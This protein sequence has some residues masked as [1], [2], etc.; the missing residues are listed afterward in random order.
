MAKK[1][2]T[3]LATETTLK[4]G[5]YVAIDHTT[6]GTKKLN[7]GAELTDLKEELEHISGISDDVKVALLQIASKVAYIDDGGQDYYDALYNALYPPADLVSISAVYTQ[8]GTVHDTDTLDSL[9][10]DLVVTALYSDQTTQTVTSYTLSGTLEVGTSTITVSYGGKTTTFTVTV[11]EYSPYT[12]YDYIKMTYGIQVIPA[13][14]GI[15]TD[16]PMASDYTLETSL[17]YD[18]TSQT[19]PQNIMGIRNGQSGTKEFG[20]FCRTDNG[21]LGYWYG[22]TDSSQSFSPLVANQ[23]NTIKVQPVG[24]SQTYPTY[25]TINVNGT[26]YSTGSTKTGETWDS[27]LGFFKYGTSATTTSSST[28]DKNAGFQIGR[29]IIKDGSNNTLHDLRPASDGTYYGLYDTVTDSFF[30]NETYAD[31]YTCGNWS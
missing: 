29:T 31:K 25:A 23:V 8:S 22:G 4:D 28:T 26:D 7:L 24:V 27:W 20:L 18:N 16:V 21:K 30:Y 11:T 3:E 19:S 6:D 15:V 17:F 12:Y 10:A 9:K 13:N 2:I 5:Q 14:S 1:R